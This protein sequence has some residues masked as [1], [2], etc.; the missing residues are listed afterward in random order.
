MNI[1]LEALSCLEVGII[2]YTELG[3]RVLGDVT[4]GYC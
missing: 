3:I 2:C 1:M 4:N